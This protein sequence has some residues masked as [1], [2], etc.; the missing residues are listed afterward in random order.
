MILQT[1][2][3]KDH[4]VSYQHLVKKSVHFQPLSHIPFTAGTDAPSL[5][6]MSCVKIQRRNEGLKLI[7]H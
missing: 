1:K 7:P 3:E 2:E 6:I 5:H 4:P